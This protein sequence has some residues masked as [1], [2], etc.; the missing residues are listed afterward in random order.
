MLPCDYIKIK[1][2]HSSNPS[3][4]NMTV[5]ELVLL[6]I[7]ARFAASAE[8]NYRFDANIDL[9]IKLRYSTGCPVMTHHMYGKMKEILKNMTMMHD[10]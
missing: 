1:F 9:I 8:K 4:A 2:K 3:N 7:T 10:G 6:R 5:R